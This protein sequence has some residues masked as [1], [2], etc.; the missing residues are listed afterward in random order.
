MS[1]IRK[2]LQATLI[3]AWLGLCPLQALAQSETNAAFAEMLYRQARDFMAAG[4]YAEACPKFAESHRLDPATGTLLNLASCHEQ[5]G[6]LAT[7][8]LEYSDAALAARRDGR[9]DRVE[10]AQQRQALLEPKLS[11]LTLVLPTE[12]DDPALELELD[13]TR[14]GRAVLN[15]P[16]PVDPGKHTVKA[17]APGKKPW[18]QV[19]EIGAVADRQTVTI[20]KLEAEPLA[21]TAAPGA[22]AAS[23]V[24]KPT[25][26]PL[27]DE[28]TTRP[29]PTSVYVAGGVTLLFAAGA[30]VT[31]AL[32]VSERADFEQ[33]K[34]A[35]GGQANSETEDHRKTALL[36]GVVNAGLWVATLGGA[37]L[38]SYLYVARP[39]R[40]TSARLSAWAGPGVAGLQLSGGF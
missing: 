18:L 13:G 10:F 37:A 21:T 19:I 6:K 7:A 34:D 29:T 3:G 23:A 31:G 39:E 9:P 26:S 30:G 2:V 38:T 14:I 8:W 17:K 25:S 15:M 20:P 5:Q 40:R 36:Y 12:A 27:A 16:T 32:Y 1:N 11:H 33:S 22:P 35:N 4:N 24:L 28:L